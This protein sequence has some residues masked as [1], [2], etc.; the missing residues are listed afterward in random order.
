M[1]NRRVGARDGGGGRLPFQVRPLTKTRWARRNQPRSRSN[2]PRGQSTPQDCPHLD[3]RRRKEAAGIRGE[4]AGG[5]GGEGAAAAATGKPSPKC[6]RGAEPGDAAT[7]PGAHGARGPPPARAE[8][9]QLLASRRV[10]DCAGGGRRAEL[11]SGCP[12][13]GAQGARGGDSSAGSPSPPSRSAAQRR[14]S[15][16]GLQGWAPH[17]QPERCRGQWEE[18]EQEEEPPRRLSQRAGGSGGGESA[19]AW[20]KSSALP[21]ALSS[22]VPRT[23]LLY[24]GPRPSE[25]SGSTPE[26][27][28]QTQDREEGGGGVGGDAQ[29][30]QPARVQQS[31]KGTRMPPATPVRLLFKSEGSFIRFSCFCYLKVSQA[32]TTETL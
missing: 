5:G 18:A 15:G 2:F 16:S 3:W 23:G 26:L 6:A 8:T 22:P 20:G 14:A 4:G 11:P 17:P 29:A 28:P 25:P 21:R 12:G 24:R 7:P 13:S 32:L 1:G 27:G 31:A 19:S 9:C 10:P 30:S